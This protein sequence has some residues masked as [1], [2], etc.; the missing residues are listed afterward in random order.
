MAWEGAW[1]RTS[2]ALGCAAVFEGMEASPAPP[3]P[4]HRLRLNA[5]GAHEAMRADPHS[6]SPAGSP[7]ATMYAGRSV[8]ADCPPET[9]SKTVAAAEQRG[10]WQ[11]EGDREAGGWGAA[12]SWHDAPQVPPA[13]TSRG[14][15]A[16]PTRG[17][18]GASEALALESYSN[19]NTVHFN[20][21]NE[22]VNK[23]FTLF[24]RAMVGSD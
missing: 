7:A 9:V 1:V 11:R 17:C 14:G 4:W 18:E 13:A 10:Q 24:E 15:A 20:W 2:D 21:K 23:K 22:H 8:G 6:Q 19:T 12:V 5:A 3:V 16:H